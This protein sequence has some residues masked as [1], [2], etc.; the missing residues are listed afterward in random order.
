MFP[1][2][3]GLSE[4][5]SS[6]NA[7]REQGRAAIADSGG[8]LVRQF[9]EMI[10][11]RIGS[12]RLSA[13]DYYKL[14]LYR[15]EIS[16]REK[17]QYISHS[18]IPQDVIGRWKIVADDKLLTY[19]VLSDAG[20]AIPKVHAIC[21]GLR[22]YRD[23]PT[24]KTEEEIIDYLRQRA[25]YPLIAK[26][27]RG[28]YS[29][30]I[31][32]LEQ[33]DSESDTIRLSGNG[34][35]R[36]ATIAGWCRVRPSGYLFQE[37]LRPHHAIREFIGEKIC[38]LRVIAMIERSQPRLFMATWKINLGENV[39][40]NYW[41]T[42]NLLARIDQKT[43]EVLQCMSGLGPRF[44]LID[45]H[46]RTG[47]PLRGFRVPHYQDAI[48]LVLRASRIFPDILMQAWDVAITDAGPV[49]LEL[50]IVGS[51]F[52]PQLVNQRG[53]WS[54]EFRAFIQTFR[55]S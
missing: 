31:F 12:G 21:H 7:L 11:L 53:L 6:W 13:E 9:L 1:L 14:R 29:R 17:R 47:R 2:S 19:S 3:H 28:M 44:Q 36:P 15:T 50:N 40:D 24:L 41:R 42:G 5:A 25:I 32:L 33:Y 35:E 46:P 39:A 8:P 26:P 20:I 49:T 23:C 37:A 38:T 55:Q 54:D 34:V 30:G 48:S 43:G 27:I 16:F 51:L 10:L 18:V 22:Q 45:R 4:I 52:I